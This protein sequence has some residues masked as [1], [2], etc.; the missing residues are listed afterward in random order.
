MAL[1]ALIFLSRF[2]SEE[3]HHTLCSTAQW[4]R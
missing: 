4:Q 2:E 1:C 3:V